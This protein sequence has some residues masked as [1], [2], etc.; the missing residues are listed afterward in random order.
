MPLIKPVRSLKVVE[1]MYLPQ[2]SLWHKKD[3]HKKERRIFLL[4]LYHPTGHF[5]NLAGSSPQD[6][7]DIIEQRHKGIEGRVV[8]KQIRN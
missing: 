5:V 3:W 4:S 1:K 2:A 7:E 8:V 6:F